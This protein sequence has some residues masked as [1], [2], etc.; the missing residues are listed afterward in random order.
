MKIPKISIKELAEYLWVHTNTITAWNRWEYNPT[1]DKVKKLRKRAERNAMTF[2]DLV[3]E[4]D[5]VI[6]R[7]EKITNCF[8]K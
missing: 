3:A 7:S 6:A 1:I 2:E 4:C 8:K 5:R